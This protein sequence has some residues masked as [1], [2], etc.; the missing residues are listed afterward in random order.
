MLP[1]LVR[2]AVAGAGTW[3]VMRQV[4]KPDRFLGR[5]FL[6]AM[7]RSHGALT[8]WGLSHVAVE[9]DFAILDVGC[10]GGATI[11]RLAAIAADGHVSGIDYADGSVAVSR[12]RNARLIDA[13]RVDVRK[14]SVSRLPFADATFDL[15]TAIETHY[16]WP[17]LTADMAEIR[18]VLKPGGALVMLAESYG[19]GGRFDAVE[20]VVMRSLSAARP[21]VEE[22]RALFIAAGYSDVEMIENRKRGWLC[23]VGR[24]PAA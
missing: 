13:G 8:R 20:R 7:N 9:R 2:Y 17:D 3:Y 19:G 11:E 12:R 14:G 1:V 21:T 23:G 24:A 6:W 10:G 18:R 4:R 16:Y 15:V 22:H 5:P